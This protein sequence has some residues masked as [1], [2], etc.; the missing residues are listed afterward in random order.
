[1][2]LRQAIQEYPKIRKA[3][4]L[5][6]GGLM[7]KLL[8]RALGSDGFHHCVRRS[9]PTIAACPASTT[10]PCCQSDADCMAMPCGHCVPVGG[11]ACGG[12]TTL[13]TN[14]CTYDVCTSDADCSGELRHL[15]RRISPLLHRGALPSEQRLHRRS[16]WNLYSGADWHGL[17]L[18]ACGLLSLPHGPVCREQ[19]L[20]GPGPRI[21]PGVSTEHQPTR[22][23]LPKYCPA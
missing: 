21:P 1:M 3:G 19:R 22:R 5:V 2:L 14:G 13:P 8:L 17:L 11:N 18:S 7:L 10:S 15:Q 16:V 20:Q 6:D 9:R 12:P 23:E 4:Q